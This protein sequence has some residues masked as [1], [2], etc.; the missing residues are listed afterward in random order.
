MNPKPTNRIIIIA[1]IHLNQKNLNILNLF[2]DFIQSQA[3]TCDYL[4]I[5]GDLFDFYIGDDDDSELVNKVAYE[6]NNL[7]VKHGV[8]IYF[9]A[10]NR[11]FLVGKNFAKRANIELLPTYSPLK[12]SQIQALLCHGDT[13]CGDDKSYQIF[14]S[15]MHQKWLQWLFRQIP[16]NFKRKIVA[17]TQNKIRQ[18]KNK[19]DFS[20]LDVSPLT[21]QKLLSKPDYTD[22][23]IIIHGHTHKQNMHIENGVVRVVLGDWRN[24]LISYLTIDGTNFYF[25]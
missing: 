3:T 14:R 20:L 5:L 21:L 17:K 9:C 22:F 8:K 4:Y 15:I 25:N 7:R 24:D 19:K 18:V 6:L 2:I 16:L 1:D 12:H 23:K 13:L 10:G 11:D